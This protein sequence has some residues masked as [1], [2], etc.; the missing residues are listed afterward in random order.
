M[1]ENAALCECCLP[2]V[3]DA[4]KREV[5]YVRGSMW[6]GTHRICREC[7][8]QWYDSDNSEVDPLDPVS[9]GN[10]VRKKH[11]LAPLVALD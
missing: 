11:G 4:C 6:H 3:C 8:C 7:F 2:P 10:R 1:T 5:D 9:V